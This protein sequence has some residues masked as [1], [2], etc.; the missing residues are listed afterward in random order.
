MSR[1]HQ[2]QKDHEGTRQVVSEQRSR[3]TSGWYVRSGFG[4]QQYHGESRPIPP[5][6]RSAPEA[7]NDSG[8]N[9]RRRTSAKRNCPLSRPI[10]FPW[11]PVTMSESRR[12][13]GANQAA[14]TAE[15]G[16]VLKVT[17]KT[18]KQKEQFEVAESSTIW[19]FKEEVAKRFK[20]P[21]DLLVLIFAGKIL[22]DQDTLS[23]HG[24]RSGFSI[25]LVIR[26]QKRPQDHPAEPMNAATPPMPSANSSASNLL[27]WGQGPSLQHLGLRYSN[28][29]EL[30][31]RLE[32][33]VASSRELVAQIMENLLFEIITS[34]LDLNTINSNPFLLGFLIG[35]T[36]MSVL[37]LD[38]TEVSDLMSEASEADGSIQ[39]LMS[40]VAQNPLVQN[41]LTN[42]DLVQEILLSNP[43]MQQLAE[44]NPEI[45]HILRN[46]DFIR[47]MIEVSSSPAML[48][49]IIRNHDRALSNLESIP[50]GYS[51]LQQLYSEIE[52]PMMNAVQAQFGSNPSA[53]LENNPPL[54][55]ASPP[56][57]MENRDPLPNPWAAR[58][59]RASDIGNNHSH[60]TSH[61]TGQNFI[62]LNFGPGAGPGFANTGGIQSMVQQLT[63]NPEFMQNMES[64]LSNPNGPAQ[65][66][67]NNT[68]LSNDGRS[69]PQDERTHQVPPELE[70]A[71]IAPLL[72]SPRAMQALLQIQ[73]GLQT[74]SAEVPDFILGL[75]DRDVELELESMEGSVPSSDSE[76]DVSLASD[77]DEPEGQ[78]SVDQQRPD[79]RFERQ[80]EQLRTMGFQDREANLQALIDTEGEIN[81]AI[82]MLTKSQPSKIL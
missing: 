4:F 68:H 79:I 13:P 77:K 33:L 17:V 53:S 9:D 63:G 49:E 75:G 2:Q 10:S 72:T 44:Q 31:G 14:I 71:E 48:Q 43:Q 46:P 36:G 40:E 64:V 55:G 82:E 18:L 35:V 56:A 47:E 70:S 30:Q 21:S 27:A 39:D 81:A 6:H 57:R 67:L 34:D 23:Q 52:E 58:T 74:L 22:K 60:R 42:T 5:S 16:G 78:G 45:N 38:P 51:A 8:K 61:S 54:D 66:L 59:N 37:G 12:A 80:M 7:R 69:R 26:S 73:L 29:S 3:P 11:I 76:E 41:I 1:W 65:M 24:V 50:G 32:E 19:A 20:A 28:V 62:V 25:H 15:S